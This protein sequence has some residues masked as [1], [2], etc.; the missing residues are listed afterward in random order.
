M[1]FYEGIKVAEFLRDHGPSGKNPIE[2]L[3]LLTMGELQKVLEFPEH[4][5][6]LELAFDRAVFIDA[7]DKARGYRNRLMHFRDPLTEAEMTRLT[8]FCDT[9]REIQL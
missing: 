7:L 3:E 9:V 8:N 2:E 5:N 6:A 4:W 1:T